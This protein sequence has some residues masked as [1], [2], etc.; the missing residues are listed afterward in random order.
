MSRTPAVSF[1]N[2]V[3]RFGEKFSLL[4]LAQEIVIPAF[5]DDQLR[6]DFG[7]TH[8]IFHKTQVSEIQS[9]LS[10]AAQVVLYGQFVK[11]TVLRRNQVF[12]PGEGLKSDEDF[13]SSAPS[14]F[15]VLILNNH[16]LIYLPEVPYAPP[17]SS[18]AL[19]AGAF[20]RTKRDHFIDAL[21]Q[22][23]R[24]SANPMTKKEL[25]EAYPAPTLEVLPLA[26][27][28]SIDEFIATFDKLTSLEFRIL[29]T[30]QEV[31]RHQTFRDLMDMKDAIHAKQT[32]LVHVNKDG[33][34]KDEV[35][36]QIHASAAAGNQQVK[37]E[38]LTPNG[39]KMSGDNHSFRLRVPIDDLPD[40]H[41]A[42]AERMLNV[43]S[44]LLAQGMLVEDEHENDPTQIA[45]LRETLND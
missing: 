8:Y 13:M 7:E 42:R 5:T 37:V 40:E 30:N 33:L 34:E 19:T 21:Y 27:A 2:F 38:G 36:Q 14:A 16:K 35:V 10:P 15:F 12:E 23:A 45:A 1:A 26:S 44:D 6:R 39:T 25:R 43:F 17:L 32:K 28:D 31:P 3:C 9:S 18:F 41:R 11:D 4:D 24:A 20:L 22:R 29:S